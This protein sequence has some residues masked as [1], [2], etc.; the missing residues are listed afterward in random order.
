MGGLIMMSGNGRCHSRRTITLMAATSDG[1]AYF[2]IRLRRHPPLSTPGRRHGGPGA[3]NTPGDKRF[4]LALI[5][6]SR[7]H[8]SKG[9]SLSSVDGHTGIIRRGDISYRLGGW[10]VGTA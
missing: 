7:R 5:I 8:P 1:E 4:C 3:S 2:D 6:L 9:D 10:G